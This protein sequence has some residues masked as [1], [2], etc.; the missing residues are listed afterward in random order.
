MDALSWRMKYR[1]LESTYQQLK[2][3]MQLNSEMEK[4][5]V[6]SRLHLTS[7]VIMFNMCGASAMLDAPLTACLL[8]RPSLSNINS[9]E[10]AL[11]DSE[12]RQKAT[13]A[14]LDTI[15][16]QLD[17]AKEAYYKAEAVRAFHQN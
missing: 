14:E 2:E 15:R 12:A 3:N 4:E 11:G 7:V 17:E 1:T 16:A 10:A 5:L 9:Q 8:L 6:R 13:E